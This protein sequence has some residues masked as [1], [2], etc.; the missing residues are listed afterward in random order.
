MKIQLHVQAGGVSL[1]AER[2]G[3]VGRERELAVLAQ[4]WVRGARALHVVGPRGIGKSRLVRH[5]S[6]WAA[7]QFGGG[8]WA[9]D[10]AAAQG[11]DGLA[12]AV[13]AGLGISLDGGPDTDPAPGLLR[14]LAGVMRDRGDC[15]VVL[16]NFDQVKMQTQAVLAYWL[17]RLPRARW[18][19]SSREG[20]GL[21]GT[22][23]L[24][25][26]PLPALEA[27][28]LFDQRARAAH[29]AYAPGADDQ[30]ALAPLLRLLGHAPAAIEAAAAKVRVLGPRTQLERWVLA[31]HAPAGVLA[32]GQ[33]GLH[34]GLC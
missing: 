22:Q 23:V 6:W 32:G 19:L 7:P 20:L 16:D 10:L 31:Q 29:W 9:C 33:T 17:A 24:R 3:F 14:Q 5:F 11:F 15:L 34:A 27:A 30:A 8:V 2:N 4:G 28:A 25:L 13:A 26:G 1:P 18:L 21:H 12:R